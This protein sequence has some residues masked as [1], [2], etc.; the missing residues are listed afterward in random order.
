[1]ETPSFGPIALFLALIVGA[2]FGFA[3]GYMAKPRA[4]QVRP[5]QKL[6]S[7]HGAE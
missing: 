7:R 2:V 5:P 1:M 4:L 3:A 6:R